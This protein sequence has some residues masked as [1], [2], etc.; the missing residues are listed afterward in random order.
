MKST[1]ISLCDRT[2]NIVKPWAEAGYPCICYD[3][4]H[5][6][7]RD[8]VRGN[9]TYRWADVRGLTPD[10]LPE[11]IAIGFAFPDCTNGALSGARDFQRKG[12]QGLIDFLTLV[13]ACRKLLCFA[14]CPWMLEQPMSRLSTCWRKPDHKF[15]PWMYGDN[16]QKETWL[17]TG[18]GFVMPPP[19]ATVKPASVKES[20]WRMPPSQDR[21]DLRAV[22]PMG[23]SR[24]VFEANHSRLMRN[25]A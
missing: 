16:Y 4:R 8:R 23:F 19:V 12:M 22:T 1:V 14:R 24:A 11:N 15:S 18:G 5:S 13:E 6:I 25:V 9:I 2:G 7:R 21:K 17:W 20:I 3:W 10:D